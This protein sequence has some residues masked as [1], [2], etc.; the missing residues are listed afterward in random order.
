MP[1]IIITAAGDPTPERDARDVTLRERI[2][3]ADFE[4]DRFAANLIERIEWAV[5]DAV[6][7][8]RRGRIA[9]R[10]LPGCSESAPEDESAPDHESAPEPDPEHQHEP[11]WA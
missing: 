1:E 11:V 10:V 7:L 3:A 4:S 9:G 2:N 6:E 5:G 8:E